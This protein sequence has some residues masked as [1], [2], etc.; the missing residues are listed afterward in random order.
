MIRHRQA[1][2]S[3]I[4]VKSKYIECIGSDQP[5]VATTGWEIADAY[6]GVF[7]QS[8]LQNQADLLRRDRHRQ[9]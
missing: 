1:M 4:G 6:L 2:P 8:V 3:I 9:W 7:N 5:R